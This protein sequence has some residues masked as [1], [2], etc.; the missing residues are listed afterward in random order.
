MAS[1]VEQIKERLDI[2]QVIGSYLKLERAGANFRARCPF[3]NERTPSFFVSPA[4]GTWHCFGCNRGGDLVSFVEEIEGVD[5]MGALKILAP[6]AGVE[7]SSFNREEAGEKERLFNL[8]EEATSFFEGELGK[9]EVAKQYLLGRGVKA[10]TIKNFRLGFAPDSWRHAADHLLTKGFTEAEIEQVGLT[11]K[12]AERGGNNRPYERFRRRVMFPLADSTGRVVGYSGRIL[13]PAAEHEAKY[14]NSPETK[15]YSKSKILYGYDK[16]KV[17]IRQ[18]DTCI[19]VEGQLDLVMAHQAGFTNT[20]AVSGTALTADHLKQLRRLASKLIMSFDSDLAG[21]RAARKAIDLGLSLDFEVKAALLP[22]EQDP[23]E[24]L[25][26]EPAIFA[27]AIDRATHIIDF[28]LAAIGRQSGDPRQLTKLAT[29]EVLPYVRQLSNSLEQAHF[30]EKIA[31]YLK[32]PAAAVWEELKKGPVVKSSL[33]QIENQKLEELDP[34]LNRQSRIG[35]LLA[36]ILVWQKEQTNPQIEP[37]KLEAELKELIGE[38]DYAGWLKLAEQ[39]QELL[40]EIELTYEG[41]N[42]LAEEI[43]DLKRSWRGEKL[44]TD[45]AKAMAGIKQAELEGNQEALDSY[46]KKCQDITKELQTLNN[47][48]QQ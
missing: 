41:S 10:E 19:L 26:T 15:L 44:K 21:I 38:E 43:A 16:G 12:T 17:A 31:N 29:T 25:K 47:Y 27:K 33:N 6:Q 22:A 28:H 4:R 46:L 8:L 45:F 7:L 48:E 1:T 14:V 32:L 37:A 34:I 42:H 5:F 3:H 2:A 35:R 11:I 20:V 36:G 23:A 18:N 39:D 24:V 40:F 9:N 30:V 13:G